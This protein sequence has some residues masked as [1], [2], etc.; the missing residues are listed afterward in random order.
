MIQLDEYY[1]KLAKPYRFRIDYLKVENVYQVF[2]DDGKHVISDSISGRLISVSKA[3]P[4]TVWI[5][6]AKKKLEEMQ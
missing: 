2:L 5:E 3:D 4:I 6:K 1:R